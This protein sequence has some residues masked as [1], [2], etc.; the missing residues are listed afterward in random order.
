MIRNLTNIQNG[1][2]HHITIGTFILDIILADIF[3]VR[4]LSRLCSIL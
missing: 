3:I 1:V 2:D 4:I